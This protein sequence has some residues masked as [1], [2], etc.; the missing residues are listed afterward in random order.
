[1]N[2]KAIRDVDRR[3][4]DFVGRFSSLFSRS[5]SRL[6]CSTY[7]KGLLLDGDRK[8]MAPMSERLGVASKNLQQFVCYTNWESQTLQLQ[9]IDVLVEKLKPEPGVLILDDTSLPKK[10]IHSVGVSRQYCGALG[11]VSNCQSIVSW[12]F[13]NK[14]YHFPLLAEL[15]L[16]QSWTGD[17][18]RMESSGV[19]KRR[20]VF[21]EKWKIALDLLE[22]LKSKVKFEV[23]AMDAGYGEIRE[24]LRE[25]DRRGFSFVAQIPESHCF[26]PHDV[27]IKTEQPKTGRPR[28]FPGVMD[29]AQSPLSAKKW[30]LHL[31]E[32]CSWRTVKIPIKSQKTAEFKAIRVRDSFHQN[33]LRAGKEMWLL[34]EKFGDGFKFYVSNLPANTEISELAKYAHSRWKI[35]Q[36]YQQLKE[37]LGLD[38]FEGRSWQGLHHHITLCFL[39]YDFLLQIQQLQTSKKKL[40]EDFDASI[41]S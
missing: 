26:W 13:A 22:R 18:T 9:A 37:E 4:M 39:A 15:Y 24:F 29:K 12:H 17:C 11:K 21:Q 19:P 7:L 20:F 35:E 30:A 16:P 3:L 5:E 6:W 1:M 31:G 32:R 33:R 34:I 8:S 36:G 41:R 28:Q 14:K 2:L 25:I 27:H 23:I 10:G 40:P 38:H